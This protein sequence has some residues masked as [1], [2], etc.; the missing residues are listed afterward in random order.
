VKS[1]Q[2]ALFGRGFDPG[3]I[4]GLM[5]PLTSRA[6]SNFQQSAG[7]PTTGYL[8]DETFEALYDTVT[9]APLFPV[10]A[11]PIETAF[12]ISVSASPGEAPLFGLGACDHIAAFVAGALIAGLVVWWLARRKI[13]RA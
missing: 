5:G 12:G 3:P 6:I 10:E 7:L 13:Q 8:T 4:D 11:I 1:L 9:A 2:E